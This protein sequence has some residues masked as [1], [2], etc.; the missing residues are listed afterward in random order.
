MKITK[1]LALAALLVLGT[2]A[3]FAEKL[4]VFN[5][6][7]EPK[8]ID[9]VLNNAIDGSNVICNI[10]EGLV[11]TKFDDTYEPGCAKSWDVSEDGLT[12]TFHLRDGLK[13]SDG[14]PLTAQDFK[15]GFERI[16]TPE[17]ASPYAHMAFFIK[18]GEDFYNGKAK[19]EDLGIETP[20]DQTVILH[21]AYQTPLVLDY[22]AFHI[23]Y[24]A[25]A[26]VV[27]KDPRGWTVNS[28]PVISNGPF[29]LTEWKHNSEL[30]I[31]K[32]PNYWDAENVKLDGVRMVMITDSNTALAAYMSGNVDLINQ[33]PP[34]MTPKLVAD[35]QAKVAPSLGTSFTV[36]NTAKKPFDDVRVRQ[37]FALAI[38][39]EVIT[40]KV[41]GGGQKPAQAFI[42]FG[43]PSSQG[44]SPDFRAEANFNPLPV[45]AD[46][47]K[48]KELLAEAGYPD[49]KGFPEVTYVYNGNPS[50]K[51]VAEALQA[52]WKAN[53]GVTVKLEQ[54]EWKV[55][56]DTRTNKQFDLARHAYISDLCDPASLMEL[57]ETSNSENCAS[58]HNE[59]YDKLIAEARKDN[60][61]QSRYE[62]LHQAEKLLLQDLP[63]LPIYYY[64][65]P[66]MCKDHLKGVFISPRNWVFFRGAELNQ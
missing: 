50:N 16:L 18:N 28:M 52:M 34:Q 45:N 7:V 10:F 2:S 23:F 32:N 56:L 53:L 20:D 65:T 13:W 44:G 54:Q 51:A 12:Y 39:R 19:K 37:A 6:A 57:W 17:V 22:L 29:M 26:D 62:K 24:P 41:T 5:L 47:K 63:V 40:K 3:A 30:T 31:K 1:V 60:N 25:R 42:P 14:K 38:D 8:T 4:A 49:G 27:E 15:Y 21:L 46:E 58:Y 33:L 48:A 9:P 36:F 59:A 43:I 11:R 55:F 66:Y 64:C 61:R 35:G